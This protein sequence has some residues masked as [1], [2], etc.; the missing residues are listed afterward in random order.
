MYLQDDHTRIPPLFNISKYLT[1]NPLVSSIYKK[2]HNDLMVP[3][4][5]SLFFPWILWTGLS[6]IQTVRMILF[7]RLVFGRC[8]FVEGKMHYSES[9]LIF[10]KTENIKCSLPFELPYKKI[11]EIF[12]SGLRSFRAIVCFK[13]W[14]QK[15]SGGK[16]KL[17]IYAFTERK[18]SLLLNAGIIVPL[19]V[20]HLT[21]F[22]GG[23]WRSSSVMC[24]P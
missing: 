17:L 21:L 14:E 15:M 10:R 18:I 9:P 3:S 5:V 1:G 12:I 23:T 11:P 4:G 6:R 8:P 22:L 2:P 13:A 16:K 20:F 24:P 19:S 7:S